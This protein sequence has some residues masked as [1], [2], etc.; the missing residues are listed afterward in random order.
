MRQLGQLEQ[1]RTL[2]SNKGAKVIALAVQDQ[3]GAAQSA[4]TT[5]AGYP[6]LA[7]K[8]HQVAE[9]YGVFDLL[10]DVTPGKATPAVFILEPN[11]QVRW[12]YI[13]KN[14]DDRPSNQAI[15]ENLP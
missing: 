10:T 12:S 4:T 14:I 5:K 3:V 6:I 13:A 11:G 9:Q 7:D 2:F 8:D 1:D 15:V